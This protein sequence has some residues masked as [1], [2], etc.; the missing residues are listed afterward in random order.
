[1]SAI[2]SYQVYRP[3]VQERIRTVYGKSR[4]VLSS[5]A[6]AIG[7]KPSYLTQI[8]KGNANLS[9]EQADK[10]NSF[11]AHDESESDYFLLMVE[12][13]RAGTVG[14]KQYFAKKMKQ[15]ELKKDNLSVNLNLKSNGAV[16]IQ[17]EFFKFWYYS[18]I[19]TL[20]SIPKFQ[21][22]DAIAK[23]LNLSL[24]LVTSALN[25]L[26][27][28][29]LVNRKNGRYTVAKTSLHLPHDAAMINA[30][31]INWRL[32]S[33]DRLTCRGEDR[34]LFYT[35]VASVSRSDFLRI[36]TLLTKVIGETKEIIR[37]SNEETLIS[38]NID[39][40]ER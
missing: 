9:L 14:L 22:P 39:L 18:A 7:C 21:D 1:M 31:H 15:I 35:S 20:T 13:E 11:L 2:Y 12:R 4:G 32:Q 16:D 37:D 36:K 30:H 10:L 5:M 27:D 23:K 28:L 8:L 26:V 24:P 6:C 19:H 38:F 29:K 17:Q 33:I 25:K 3:Y 34:D 40:F